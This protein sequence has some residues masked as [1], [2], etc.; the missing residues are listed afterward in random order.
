[1]NL[2][3][4][5]V[6]PAIL[7]LLSFQSLFRMLTSAIKSASRG[8]VVESLSSVHREL[9]T[10]MR[11]IERLLNLEGA[12]EKVGG[13]LLSI[14]YRVQSL[15]V[16]HSNS[17]DHAGYQQLQVSFSSDSAVSSMQL[18]CSLKRYC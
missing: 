15:L 16:V 17:F 18:L 14:L 5:S 8:K 10:Y 1:M 13:H 12:D 3:L 9:R 2:Q 11:D 7:A 6:T 4:L